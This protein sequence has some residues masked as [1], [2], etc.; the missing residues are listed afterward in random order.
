MNCWF[1]NGLSSEIA[2]GLRVQTHILLHSYEHRVWG[3]GVV[4]SRCSSML[5]T[6]KVWFVRKRPWDGGEPCTR[7]GVAKRGGA[8]EACRVIFDANGKQKRLGRSI[9]RESK[10]RVN[11]K[12]E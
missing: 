10:A 9:T 6:R 5:V 12:I 11:V 7:Y 4:S 3:G 8:N 2:T 1:Y